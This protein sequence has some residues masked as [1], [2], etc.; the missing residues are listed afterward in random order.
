MPSPSPD[1]WLQHRELLESVSR[2]FFLSIK[3]L[4]GAVREPVSLGYLLARL[5]DT[6]ADSGKIPLPARLDA[7]DSLNEKVQSG[8]GEI[9]LGENFVR[10]TSHPGEKELLLR[11]S[12]ILRWLTDIDSIN[13]G[14]VIEV[15]KTI[16]SGQRW[17]LE[18]FGENGGEVSSA[19]ETLN[20]TYLVAGCVG[21][22]WTKVGF[23]NLE[24]RFAAPADLDEMM[25]SGKKLGQGL[26]LINIIRDLYEDL[27]AGR[28]YLPGPEIDQPEIDRW[29]AQCRDFLDAGK[30]YI[31]KVRN[32][33]IRFATALPLCL[34]EETAR[35]LELAG[36]EKITSEK[37]KVPRSV[38]L[39]S[40]VRSALFF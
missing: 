37:V 23:T 21:E 34:A 38:V 6:I 30:Q 1:R 19:E 25:V 5:S 9:V 40:A 17:D 7:L 10:S 11:A 8:E 26:Q 4:P 24:D 36:V 14:H 27:P 13:H 39:K 18:F 28:R 32:H 35:R 20:Y 31:G 33:R 12:E 16:I 2:S 15:M 29:L 3:V 22:F